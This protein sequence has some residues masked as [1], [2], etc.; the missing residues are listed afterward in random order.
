MTTL[1]KTDSETQPG[2]QPGGQTGGQTGAQP[3]PLSE[4]DHSGQPA[5]HSVDEFV[6]SVPDLE[7]AR[8]FYTAFGLQVRDEDGG[9]GLYSLGRRKRWALV[10]PGVSKR[11]LW[12]ALGIYARDVEAFEQRLDAEGAQRIAA[13][14]GAPEAGTWLRTP[15]GL[16]VCL[17]I[18]EKCS[19]DAK[20]P[21]IFAPE[22]SAAGRAP[23]R[24]AVKRV[25]PRRLS[26]I[27]LFT[28]DVD[29]SLGFYE[30]VFG[31][32]LSDRS[33]D[34]VAFMHTPHGS[35]HHLVAF[36]R[37]HAYGL[38]HSSWDVQSFDE[39]GLGSQQ[40]AQAGYR[41]GWGIGRHVLGSNY[42]RYVRDPWG[43][44]AE[45]SFDIDHIPAGAAWPAG[46][47]PPEDSLYV[48]GP[49]LPEEFIRNHEA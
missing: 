44:Y 39:V 11:L 32:R 19:P 29:A 25:M 8:H 13:P 27:L 14:P 49:D 17:R 16:P 5:V 35:D 20:S 21:R 46:D 9:L 7:V 40:M 42:F 4:A 24:N 33:A 6:F 2:M 47:Y 31:L 41:D 36:A 38:H 12:L 1:T 45:Y 3:G 10:L 34:I 23:Q 28:P 22:H 37:S 48:W 43:S 26:H 15:D 18:A 30:R